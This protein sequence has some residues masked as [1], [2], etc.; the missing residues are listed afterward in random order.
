MPLHS[1][2]IRSGGRYI[3][4]YTDPV[5]QNGTQQ[6]R[7]AP[8]NISLSL[9]HPASDLPSRAS[10]QYAASSLRFSDPQNE[11]RQHVL[12][13]PASDIAAACKR[14]RSATGKEAVIVR[15]EDSDTIEVRDSLL[16]P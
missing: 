10:L 11:A 16:V 8:N 15:V 5:D 13:F 2:H 1:E 9:L 3:A 12:Q 7:N 6:I 14:V 4:L